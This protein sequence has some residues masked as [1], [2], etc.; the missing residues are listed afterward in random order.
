MSDEVA[1][2]LANSCDRD[3]FLA[4]DEARWREAIGWAVRPLGDAARAQ[5]RAELMRALIDPGP[6]L[7][8]LP[9]HVGGLD[10]EDA[11]RVLRVALEMEWPPYAPYQAPAP[12]PAGR[13]APVLDRCPRCGGGLETLKTTATGSLFLEVYC[14]ECR[15]SDSW[16]GDDEITPEWWPIAGGRYRVGLDDAETARLIAL[17]G[18]DDD[19]LHGLRQPTLL[20]AR[21][22]P[23]RDV[24]LAAFEIQGAIAPIGEVTFALAQEYATTIGAALP[25]P[26]QWERFARGADRHLIAAWL[27]PD[28]PPEWCSDGSQRGGPHMGS[29]PCPAH[30]GTGT[31]AAIR[32]VRPGATHRV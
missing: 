25:T 32:C 20:A 13:G 31:R 26:E 15:F 16:F 17:R 10:E 7:D 11:R 21:E 23:A 1:R 5:L 12:Q 18:E 2:V 28:A 22:T 30:P 8:A 27:D 6:V 4:E 24:E 14:F 19:I 3:G 9:A 29:P